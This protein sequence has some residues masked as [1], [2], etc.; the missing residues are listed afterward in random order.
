M[1]M[2][3][4]PCTQPLDHTQHEALSW[5]DVF[6]FTAFTFTAFTFTAVS[7]SGSA[8]LGIQMNASLQ[9]T[10]CDDAIHIEHVVPMVVS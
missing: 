7:N 4:P 6:T 3:V 10:H 2:G 5:V 1:G 8:Y 9:R